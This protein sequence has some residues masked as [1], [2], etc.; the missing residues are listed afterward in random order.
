MQ[1]NNDYMMAGADTGLGLSQIISGGD[2]I[3]ELHSSANNFVTANSNQL[4]KAS[5]AESINSKV[6]ASYNVMPK[7]KNGSSVRVDSTPGVG[8][9]AKNLNSLGVASRSKGRADKISNGRHH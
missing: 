8:H 9:Q 6:S 4:P 1:N 3:S 5:A 2:R 7:S